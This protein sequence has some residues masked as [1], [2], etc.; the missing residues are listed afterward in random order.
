M[1]TK[2]NHL[3]TVEL[4]RNHRFDVQGDDLMEELWRRLELYAAEAKEQAVQ[5]CYAGEVA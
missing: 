1:Q 2:Y 5:T 3:T 4:L